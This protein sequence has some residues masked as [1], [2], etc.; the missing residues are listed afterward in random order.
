MSCLSRAMRFK[1]FVL[2]L[3]PYV[4]R[5]TVSYALRL[6]V[7]PTLYVSLSL[8]AVVSPSCCY[9]LFMFTC[10]KR[11]VYRHIMKIIPK[12]CR[13]APARVPS[14]GPSINIKFVFNLNM[15]CCLQV[16]FD[17]L[18]GRENAEIKKSRSGN[19]NKNT[20]I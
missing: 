13:M 18:H 19:W 10:K 12:L 6:A 5:V 8:S 9:L 16:N 11:N 3:T 1:M 4:L 7:S 20:E 2:C 14:R 17:N 15:I